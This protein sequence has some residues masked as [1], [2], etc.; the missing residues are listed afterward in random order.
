EANQI[1]SWF[2]IPEGMLP[3]S[4]ADL[5]C[6]LT[7]MYGS[8]EIVV[9]RTARALAREIVAPA[10][11]HVTR[12]LVWF[13]RLAT[14]G[15]L[16]PAIRQAYGFPWGVRREQALRL[17]AGCIRRLLVLTPSVVRHWPSARASLHRPQR[18]GHA[19]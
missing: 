7:Q 11:V 2:E 3:A 12:P 8:G 9:T 13:N 16:P 15:L 18:D 14:V 5:E 4:V 6:Y 17:S 1:A 10:S 19:A